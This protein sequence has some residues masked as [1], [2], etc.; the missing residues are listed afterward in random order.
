MF[1]P[2]CPDL[3]KFFQFPKI[4]E[5]TQ[6][7]Y[8]AEVSVSPGTNDTFSLPGKGFDITMKSQ[9]NVK[10]EI[11][12]QNFENVLS[13]DQ[14]WNSSNIDSNVQKDILG[15]LSLLQPVAFEKAK[16]LNQ[17]KEVSM[18]ISTN[19]IENNVQPTFEEKILRFKSG[20]KS[21]RSEKT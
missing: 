11:L 2:L 3:A 14:I 12:Q 10:Q 17:M 5:T 6:T 21:K 1:S 15:Q 20:C 7:T 4:N 16:D 19:I 13:S 8:S 18:N 9:V